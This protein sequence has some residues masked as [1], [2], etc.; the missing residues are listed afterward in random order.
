MPVH[1]KQIPHEEPL[2][3]PPRT[4]RWLL[5]II[6][7]AI[8]GAILVLSVWPKELT[9]YSVWFWFCT[10]AI[11]FGV[12]LLAF[13]IRLRCYENKRDRVLWWNHLHQQQ[14]EEQILLGQKATGILGMS[15]I[16]PV[17]S[18]K[19]SQALL[20]G[21]SS[22]QT[23][24]SPVLRN[25]VSAALLSTPL[26]TLTAAGYQHRLESLLAIVLRQLKA[27]LDKYGESLS[28]RLSH[29]GVL[30]DD[31]II[32][33]WQNIFTPSA[34]VKEVIASSKNDGM[35][36]IDEW[37]DS[38][39]EKVVLSVEINLFML[40]RDREAESVSALLM[41][42]PAWLQKQNI[43]PQMWVHRP[44]S[45]MDVTESVTDAACWGKLNAEQHWYFWRTQLKS[46]VLAKILQAMEKQGYLANKEGDQSLDDTF[47]RP[48]AAAGNISL[49]C[50][51]EYAAAS[52]LPQWVIAGD[53]DNNTQMV[54][55][56][57]G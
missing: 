21:A 27:E 18:N 51:C 50:A 47:G 25:T 15:Y 30:N 10:L 23:L 39:N 37:L 28:I 24:Y 52:G 46:D 11:P 19:L 36:W 49:I 5:V 43:K 14:R 42:S 9:T 54:V 57:P 1:L 22:L 35:M 31:Q 41:A 20:R 55:V 38:D 4:S 13:I 29:D 3:S 48:G 6:L 40:P 34:S 17:A 33:A 12:G 56:R 16:T 32:T 26:E 44:V 2:P 8:A 45:V 53:N 7:C